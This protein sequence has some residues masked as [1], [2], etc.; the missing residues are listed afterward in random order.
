M[1]LVDGAELGDGV[2][3]PLDDLDMGE[4]AGHGAGE[5]GDGVVEVADA[6][7]EL[8]DG[9]DLVGGE[10]GVDVSAGVGLGVVV[11]LGQGGLAPAEDDGH[12]MVRGLDAEHGGAGG[13][14][15]VGIL[16]SGVGLEEGDGAGQGE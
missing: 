3:A 5:V 7:D 6:V 13:P 16:A 1:P 11:H 14:H 10:G 15:E 9:G 4:G 2:E 8:A 12:V